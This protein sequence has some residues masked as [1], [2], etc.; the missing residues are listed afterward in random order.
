MRSNPLDNPVYAALTQTHAA[1]AEQQLDFLGY[2]PAVC[3]FGCITTALN[4]VAGIDTYGSE[5]ER[6]FCVG[7]QPQLSEN[8]LIKQ[9][10]TCDQMVL[11]TPIELPI[12]NKIVHLQPEHYNALYDLVNLVQPGYFT[13][14]TPKMGNYY[15]I[16]EGKELIAVTGERMKM[17][18]FTEISAVI[19]HPNHTGKGLAKQLVTHVAN[20]IFA[21]NKLPF[22]HVA[23]NNLGAIKLYEKL[24]FVFR[25]KISFWHLQSKKIV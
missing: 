12:M 9:E 1:F 25:R 21:E 11:E 13:H 2:N 20:S 17:N 4:K 14:E 6:F 22:L 7:E 5:I 16:F 24:G 18:A 8:M 15:G 3:P 23:E 10:L 19:T